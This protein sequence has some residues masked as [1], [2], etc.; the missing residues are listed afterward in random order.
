MLS[1]AVKDS[2]EGVYI[3]YRLGVS[4]FALRRPNAKTKYLQEL[5]QEVLYADSGALLA[6]NERDLQMMVDKFSQ[7]S[8]LFGLTIN[9]NK[10][11]VSLSL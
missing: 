1:Q 10:T 2:K 11:E 4:L 9:I 3:K 5:I 6:H 8:K 7:A